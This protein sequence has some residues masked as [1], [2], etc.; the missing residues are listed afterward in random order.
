MCGQ[1][2]GGN[3]WGSVWR[4]CVK[5]AILRNL[6][7]AHDAFGYEYEAFVFGW[8][9]VSQ[10]RQIVTQSAQKNGVIHTCLQVWADPSVLLPSCKDTSPA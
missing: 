5:G 4:G 10:M 9:R 7:G 2:G 6:G 8:K 1:N 3:V